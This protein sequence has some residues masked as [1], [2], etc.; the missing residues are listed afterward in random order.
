[1]FGF[2][3]HVASSVL[4]GADLGLR[5]VRVDPVLVTGF[6]TGAFFVKTSHALGV[7]RI[8]AGFNGESFDILPILFFGIARDEF[9]QRSIGL[10]D[11]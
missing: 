3:D 11:C 1:M 2:V 6:A 4:G 5:I 8:N 9:S 7:I 10:D